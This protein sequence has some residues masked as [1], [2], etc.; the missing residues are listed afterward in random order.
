[1]KVGGESKPSISSAHLVVQRRIGRPAK[2]VNPLVGEPLPRGVQQAVG[3]RLVVDALEEAEEAA[4][5][6]VA[7]VVPP[8]EDGGDPAADLAAARRPRN[9]C[10]RFRS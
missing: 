3:R 8:V 10:T 2:T 9:V 6:P 7:F 5:L 4:T 1:M